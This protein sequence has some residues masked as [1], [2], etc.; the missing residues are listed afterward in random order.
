[1][2][3]IFTFLFLCLFFN[4]AAQTEADALAF[5]KKLN[6]NYATKKSSPLEQKDLNVFKALPFYNWNKKY[7]VI[8]SLELTPKAP[9]FVMNTTTDRKPLYQQYAI[10]SFEIDGNRIQLSIYQSQ[11]SKYDLQYKDYLFL[12]FKDTTN[13]VETYEGGRF[14]DVFISSIYNNQIVLDFN[15]AYNPY[16]AYNH[17]YSCPVPPLENHLDIPIKAGVQKGIVKK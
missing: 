15:E 14:I 9:L 2:K 17:A 16:C 4:S 11:Q 5:Q 6:T 12:P 1:M 3:F 10:A 7:R 13:G 8:A